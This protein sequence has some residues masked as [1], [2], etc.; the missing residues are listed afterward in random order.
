M[1]A[2][3]S[4]LEA[5]YEVVKAYAEEFDISK[6]DSFLRPGFDQLRYSLSDFYAN[7]LRRFNRSEHEEEFSKIEEE[8][9]KI[10]PSTI[11]EIGN[12]IVGYKIVMVKYDERKIDINGETITVIHRDVPGLAK[13]YIP[14]DAKRLQ[15]FNNKCRCD[16]AI[17]T[18][19][20]AKIDNKV[21]QVKTGY[22]LVIGEIFFLQY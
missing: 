17:V 12:A 15:S 2:R 16:R 19:I 5:L 22:S 21:F 7:A 18:D 3:I 8:L 20:R 14:S 6:I 10:F 4:I 11:P 1:K 9:E 13:L